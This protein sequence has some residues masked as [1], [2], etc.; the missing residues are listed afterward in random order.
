MGRLTGDPLA[1]GHREVGHGRFVVNIAAT[2]AEPPHTHQTANSTSS[3][4]QLGSPQLMVSGAHFKTM[5]G[6]SELL[7]STELA[8]V[9]GRRRMKKVKERPRRRE[10]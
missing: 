7:R 10:R 5:L 6:R 3:N 9:R 8:R 2:V 4:H 1:L